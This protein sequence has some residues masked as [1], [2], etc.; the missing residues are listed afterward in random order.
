[1]INNEN[2]NPDGIF[3]LNGQIFSVNDLINAM[4][5][6]G[7]RIHLTRGGLSIDG[8]QISSISSLEGNKCPLASTCEKRVALI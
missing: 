3:V 5:R 7:L 6:Q 2:N 4:R 8:E 1:M